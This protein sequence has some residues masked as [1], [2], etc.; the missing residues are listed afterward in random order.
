MRIAQ[1]NTRTNGHVERRQ[2]L[3]TLGIALALLLGAVPARAARVQQVSLIQL[4]ANP[5]KYHGKRV[6]V[7]GWLHLKFED[8]G[9][10]LT[11]KDADYLNAKNGVWVDF[12]KV[13]RRAA[14]HRSGAKPKTNAYFDCK[15]VLL[16][17]R[18]DMTRFGH[19]GAW[20]GTLADVT[21][22]IE[23]TRWFDGRKVVTKP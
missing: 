21:V 23:Q 5:A 17:G 8:Q 18:F 19:L 13:V 16:E 10:Y 7:A 20:S 2:A 22:L 9:I 11:K 3:L 1:T 15:L 14:A 6:M 4:I 12:G